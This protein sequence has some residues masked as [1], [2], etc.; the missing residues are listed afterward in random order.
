M[1]VAMAT[2]GT[3]F[4][5]PQRIQGFTA[6]V[7]SAACEWFLIFLSLVDTVLSYLLTKFASYCKL[8]TPCVLCSRLESA[9]VGRTPILYQSILCSGHRSEISSLI[10]CYIHSKVAADNGMC[11]HCLLS[12]IAKTKPDRKSHRWSAGKLGLGLGGGS[13]QRSLLRQDSVTNSRGSRSCTCC[14]EVGKPGQNFQRSPQIK[15]EGVVLKPNV[16]L[17]HVPRKS[18]S[19][20]L[21]KLRR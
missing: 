1:F 3:S 16:P 8:Q 6:V 7:T 5:K 10:S 4:A 2:N 21:D 13:F 17:A 12:F 20:H 18:H 15:S 19:G 9:L 14:G 11:D